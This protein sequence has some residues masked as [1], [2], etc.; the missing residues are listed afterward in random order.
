MPGWQQDV[1]ILPGGEVIGTP[2]SKLIFTGTTKEAASY[3]P[4]GTLDAWQKSVGVMVRGNPL[5]MTAIACSLAGPL[6]DLVGMRDG[7]GLHLFARTSSGKSTCSDIAM[8][9]WAN[10]AETQHSWDGTALGL[11]NAAEACNDTLLYLDEIGTGDARKIGA[12]IYSMLNGAA[13][14]QGDRNGGNRATR[15]WRLTLISTGEVALSQLL[16]EGGQTTRGGQEIRL[17]N[18]PA[19]AGKYR[20]FDCI[21]HFADGD[22]FATA[23]TNAARATFGTLGRAFVSWLIQHRSEVPAWVEQHQEAWLREVPVGAAPAVKRATRKFSVLSAAA[24]MASH[25]GL[26]GWTAEEAIEAVRITWQR[27][28]A[29]FGTDDRDDSRLI[30][31]AVGM[32]QAHQYSRFLTLPLREHAAAL[33]V[34]DLMGYKR[35]EATGEM[36]FLVLPTAFKNEVIRGYEP[37]H[38][39]EMLHRAGILERPSVSNR[40]SINAGKG[41]GQVYRMRLPDEENT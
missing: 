36:L 37:R 24:E 8:S 19:D 14:L 26:T 17:L 31:Q 15:T 41:I 18:I 33:N 23:L 9:V 34:R 22:A 13:K 28:L 11:A 29:N 38:A 20:A 10:P 35:R 1:F 12:A 21:H 25:A 2:R 3:Q 7:I 6:L 16:Q 5:P 4:S 30:E 32:L 27:W 40:W 39:C